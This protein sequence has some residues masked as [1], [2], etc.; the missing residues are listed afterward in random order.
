LLTKQRRK[1]KNKS[2]CISKNQKMCNDDV[3]RCILKSIPINDTYKTTNE[4]EIKYHDQA[5][6]KSNKQLI[7]VV[8]KDNQQ[9]WKNKWK[10]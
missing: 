7:V 4:M 2:N 1:G 10:L 5:S 6:S 8:G 9:K 3:T